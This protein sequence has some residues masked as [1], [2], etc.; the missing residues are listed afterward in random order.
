MPFGEEILPDT[1]YRKS[2]DK[3]NLIPDRVKQ[4][5]TGYQRDQ[6][7]NLDFAEARY[8]NSNHGRFTTVDPLLASGKSS[9]PQTFNRYVYVM[10]NPL[11]STD[12]SG[13]LPVYYHDKGGVRT[14]SET[15]HKGWH[16]QDSDVVIDATNGGRYRI[17][18]NG[19]IYIGETAALNRMA[20]TIARALNESSATPAETSEQSTAEH[21]YYTEGLWKPCIDGQGSCGEQ[22]LG[23]DLLPVSVSLSGGAGGL[24]VEGKITRNGDILGG[25]NA[26]VAD[27]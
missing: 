24:N 20:A 27:S 11:N 14:Y 6:E 3:Y 9:N 15:Y 4:K 19:I 26:N 18:P 22:L 21:I 1:A 12:P 13:M 23:Q 2:T 17:T 7:T 25:L 5:F 8:Y 16:T 10:N